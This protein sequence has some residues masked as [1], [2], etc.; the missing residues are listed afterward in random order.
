MYNTNPVLAIDRLNTRI[1]RNIVG[2]FLPEDKMVLIGFSEPSENAQTVEQERVGL[3]A[4]VSKHILGCIL[5]T[6]YC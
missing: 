6:N 3:L 2:M 5:S 1:T 4:I